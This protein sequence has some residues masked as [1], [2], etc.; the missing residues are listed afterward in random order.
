MIKPLRWQYIIK[1]KRPLWYQWQS[2]RLIDNKKIEQQH[3]HP[4]DNTHD[5]RVQKVKKKKI[6]M[7]N[8]YKRLT[9]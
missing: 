7:M 3:S 5:E 9:L 8:M 2:K 4:Y 6:R 1:E